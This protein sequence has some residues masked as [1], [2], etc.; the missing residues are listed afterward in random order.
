MTA[1]SPA[2]RARLRLRVPSEAEGSRRR[3][4]QPPPTGSGGPAPALAGKL[5]ARWRQR[6]SSRG[7]GVINDSSWLA[8]AR[9]LKRTATDRPAALRANCARCHSVALAVWRIMVRNEHSKLAWDA[10]TKGRWGLGA[11]TV[12]ERDFPWEAEAEPYYRGPEGAFY[13]TLL[14]SLYQ[15]SAPYQNRGPSSESPPT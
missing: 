11:E 1:A 10:A 9:N 12:T 7:R 14:A 8:A 4:R 6:A 13:C 3:Q 15:R 2:P 5:E